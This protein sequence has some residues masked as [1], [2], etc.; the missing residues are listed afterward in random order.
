MD[1]PYQL[2]LTPSDPFSPCLHPHVD[3]YLLTGIYF[4]LWIAGDSTIFVKSLVRLHRNARRRK[5]VE[6]EMAVVQGL[7][8]I[9]PGGRSVFLLLKKF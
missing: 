4:P 3:L 7:V 9:G 5:L 6:D 8:R 1:T 2:T